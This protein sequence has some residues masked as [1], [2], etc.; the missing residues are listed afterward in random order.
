[1]SDENLIKTVSNR[2]GI[3]KTISCCKQVFSF[4]NTRLAKNGP[5]PIK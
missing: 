5:C 2:S 3:D 4:A 1:V